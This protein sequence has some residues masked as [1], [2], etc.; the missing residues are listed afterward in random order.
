MRK[1]ISIPT[2]EG[3]TIAIVPE[4]SEASG[5]TIWYAYL[6]NELSEALELILVV[7][8]GSKAEVQTSVMRHRLD[9]LPPKSFAKI[10]WVEDSVLSL[11]NRFAL[12]FY[13]DGRLYDKIFEFPTNSIHE[14]A[15]VTL[16]ILSRKGIMAT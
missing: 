16:P 1:D 11:D 7:S 9:R 8:K 6:I 3:V 4:T 13:K 12:T 5:A 2:V 14:D 15:C 10:E